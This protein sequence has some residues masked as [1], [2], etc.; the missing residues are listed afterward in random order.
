[1]L[2]SSARG[3]PGS[4]CCTG[5]SIIVVSRLKLVYTRKRWFLCCF[6]SIWLSC[7]GS[8]VEDQFKSGCDV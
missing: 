4:G 3:F 8:S 6:E 7:F 1:M 2:V 5:N